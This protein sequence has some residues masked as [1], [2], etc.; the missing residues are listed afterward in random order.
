[1]GSRLRLHVAYPQF[2]FGI[3]ATTSFFVHH[4]ALRVI[5]GITVVIDSYEFV[6]RRPTNKFL[7]L[8]SLV[9][10]L[11]LL[12]F[13]IL[14]FTLSIDILSLRS[15]LDICKV[16]CICIRPK[17]VPEHV[18]DEYL[19][20]KMRQRVP[21]C[22]STA[23]DSWR[24]THFRKGP[25]QRL[26]VLTKSITSLSANN[27]RTS[28]AYPYPWHGK[29]TPKQSICQDARMTLFNNQGKPL[30]Y[31]KSPTMFG[32]FLKH[33]NPLPLECTTAQQQTLRIPDNFT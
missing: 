3:Q 17:P 28:A 8:C 4:L 20:A 14:Y 29:V 26:T 33:R 22:N 6:H 23:I 2:N 5:F 13:I 10:S 16:I 27:E 24:R 31:T 18:N 12:S 11:I 1:V 19:L 32:N 25:W 7:A 15:Y 9:L 21:G 30:M